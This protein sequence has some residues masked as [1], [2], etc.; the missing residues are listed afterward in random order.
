MRRG[1]GINGRHR[2]EGLQARAGVSG[3]Y[4]Y[5]DA[6]RVFFIL[7]SPELDPALVAKYRV[8]NGLYR[9]PARVQLAAA[10]QQ[11]RKEEQRLDHT[12]R[13]CDDG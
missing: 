12:K 10:E 2:Q 8:D 9:M 7:A 13:L 3:P 4:P 1:P 5:Y 6:G 11:L